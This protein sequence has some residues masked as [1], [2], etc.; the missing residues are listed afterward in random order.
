M[1]FSK[2]LEKYRQDHQHPVNQILH[3]I[4]IPS[5]IISLP[6][7]FFYWKLALVLFIGGW[8]LQFVGHFFEGKKP[9]FFSNPL[10]LII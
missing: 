9:T 5:I 8:V 4:G 10:F 2:M 7:F 6:L 1:N 3:Y